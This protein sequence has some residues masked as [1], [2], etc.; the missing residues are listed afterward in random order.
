MRIHRRKFMRRICEKG[1]GVI[2][3]GGALI[4]ATVMVAGTLTVGVDGMNGIFTA[5]LD[6]VGTMLLSYI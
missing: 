4:V 3:Y 2:E 6:S 5:I 1:Q